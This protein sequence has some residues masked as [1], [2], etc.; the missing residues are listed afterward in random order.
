[1]K[2]QLLLG[3]AFSAIMGFA[4]AMGADLPVKAAPYRAP[5][6]APYNWT[7]FYVGGNVG[8][9]WG[10]GDLTYNESAFGFFGLPTSISGSHNLDGAIGGFQAGYNWQLDNRWVAGFE[11]DFQWSGEK[12]STTFSDPYSVDFEGGNISGNLSSKLLWFGTVRGRVG[13][14]AT[15]TILIYVTG[16]L[17]YGRLEASGSITDTFQGSTFASWSFSRSTTKAGWTVGGGV[18]GA[19]ANTREWTWKVEYLYM[20]LGSVNGTGY[21]NDFGGPYN[22]E[23]KFTDNIVRAGVNYRFP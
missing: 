7:G 20:D 12:A 21:D 1:M 11:T 18:E 15:P 19:I 16:G 23:A 5:V 22:W 2:K 14:L 17:A 3:V 10:D 13:V 8:Y 6:V 9:S 4:P